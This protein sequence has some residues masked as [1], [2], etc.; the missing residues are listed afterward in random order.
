LSAAAP[1]RPRLRRALRRLA[2]ACASVAL[3]L[4]LLEGSLRFLLFSDSALAQ[5]IGA[6]LRMA[7]HYAS[8]YSGRDF[9]KLEARFKRAL[10]PDP[11]RPAYD[12]R[13]G[14]LKPEIDP[15]TLR[16]ADEARLGARRPVLL[17]GDSFAA[18]MTPADECWQALMERSDLGAGHALLNYGVVGYGL[19]QMYLLLRATLDLYA[20]RDP[21]VVI[22]ILVD[23]DLDRCY[24]AL[25]DLPKPWFTLDDGGELVLHPPL[26]RTP[27][28]HVALDPPG[29]TSYVWRALVTQSGLVKPW[30]VPAWT[31]EGDHVAVKQ[32]LATALFGALERELE[33]RGIERFYLLFHSRRSATAPRPYLWQEPF[34]YAELERRAL[35]FVSSKRALIEHVRRTKTSLT[36][37]FIQDET[38]PNHYDAEGNAVVFETLRAGLE[39]R[40]E[41]YAFLEGV[42]GA[43]SRVAPAVREAAGA[44]STDG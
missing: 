36:D 19:D 1:V 39:R 24:L 23:D 42:P 15:V 12:E 8:L 16:H 27:L 31:G 11:R 13:F 35:P 30:D 28:A 10:P 6:P 40:F 18:C 33:A 26:A 41:P 17:Y 2:L 32:A 44:G 29:V 43:S 5:R 25:R 4:L 38:G 20:E 9:W 14:W 3:G 34:L 37:L 22:G 7:S 21:V